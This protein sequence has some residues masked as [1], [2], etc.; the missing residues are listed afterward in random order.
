MTLLV[1]TPLPELLIAAADVRAARYGRR[2]TFSP[3]VFIPLTELCQDRCGYCTFAKPPARVMAPFSFDSSV[4][5]ASLVGALFGVAVYLVNFYGMTQ[6]FPWFAQA[7]GWTSF[8]AHIV[9]GL[10]AADAYLRLER[11]VGEA[12]AGG[13]GSIS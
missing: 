10:V 7:R 6:L 3:K 4:G 12:G 5:M 8:M 1:D 9:F 11:K 2:V 13:T